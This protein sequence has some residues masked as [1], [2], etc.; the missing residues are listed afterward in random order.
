MKYSKIFI[1]TVKEAPKDATIQSHILM[2]RAGMIKKLSSGIYSFL[3]I[4]YRV[5]KK[6]EQIVREEMDR[7]GCNEFFLPV[8]I[9]ADLW[10]TSTRWFSMGNEL[11]RLKDRSVQDFV[12]APTHEEAFTYILKDHI[13]SYRDLP[14]S[15]YHIGYKF[16]DEI[17]PRFGVMRGKTFIM[18]DAYSF[19]A[20]SDEESL[21]KTYREMAGA[22]RNI[23]QRCGLETIPVSADSGT[24]GGSLSE[25]FMVPSQ[26]GEEVIVQCTRCGYVANL[27]KASSRLD[28][29]EYESGGT[30][31]MVHT[32]G[33]K[34]IE[35]VAGFLHVPPQKIIKSL[36]FKLQEDRYAIALIRG[37]LDVN[38]TKLKN[39]LGVTELT[40]AS[41][42]EA[43]EK[44]GVPLGFTGPIGI[45]ST[46]VVADH[47]IQNIRGGV[48]GSNRRDYHYINVDAGRD[49]TPDD[50]IDIRLV[51]E[52]DLCPNCGGE[53]KMFR[54]IELGHIFKLGDKY[55][56]AFAVQYLD[57]DGN[58]RTP[59]MGCYGIGIERT[60]AAV[61]EQNH[62]QKGIIWPMSVAPFEVFLL[63]VKY[64]G[65]VKVISE[66]LMHILESLGMEVLLDDRGER[67]GV[68]FNDA[69]LIGV[70]YRVTIGERGLSNNTV[71]FH[72]RRSGRNELVPKGRIVEI[73]KEKISAAKSTKTRS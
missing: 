1:P 11:F 20:E 58:S 57:E 50:Y 8:L 27:E 43:M 69:D 39:H 34:T 41:E 28:R 12:L 64:E 26:V 49:F 33:A 72:D 25:E 47:S 44:L 51:K 46:S 23:F 6:I 45:D 15:V 70:P 60:M 32:P 59:I 24:M 14:L 53:M 16:R 71:E 3:P 19:H 65:E 42:S 4:G 73:L 10:K 30:L 7:I 37:D 17:R 63:P 61:I 62:D 31:E 67:A 18:K 56:K 52:N 21:D 40:P 9:P 68:K 66:R 5:L 2:I 22:Y 54:G 35:A 29:I 13:K 55:T 36:V 48:A 38:E